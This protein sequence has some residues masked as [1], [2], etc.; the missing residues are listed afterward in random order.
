MQLIFVIEQ[1]VEIGR[2][3]RYSLEGAGYLVC[4]SAPSRALSEVENRRPAAIIVDAT[5]AEMEGL[6]LCRGLRRLGNLKRTPVVVLAAERSEEFRVQALEWGADDCIPKAFSARELVARIQAVLRRFSRLQTQTLPMPP[7]IFRTGD[8]E[9]D[10]SAMRISVRGTEVSATT[11]EFRLL[12]YLV[13]NQGR[14][15]TRDQLLD[16][17]WGE[18]QF[19]T[20]RSVDACIRRIREKIERDS[21]RPAYLKTVR[22][23]GYRLD[24][25]P[26]PGGRREAAAVVVTAGVAA[27]D[28]R[29]FEPDRA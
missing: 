25:S 23:V 22:G 5:L 3:V 21:A 26:H 13:R 18:M 16:A 2:M 19:V 11:L 14:V 9:I 1:D 27:G 10:N 12:D 17:V 7:T 8:I 20:P 6:E 4:V 24:A 15:F 28:R 29:R